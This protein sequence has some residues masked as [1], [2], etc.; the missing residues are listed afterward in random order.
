MTSDLG[1]KRVD[2]PRHILLGAAACWAAP[3]G[4]GC[5]TP[6]RRLNRP[7]AR[8]DSGATNYCL[9]AACHERGVIVLCASIQSVKVAA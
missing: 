7:V 5:G 8:D 3:W 9:S 2:L 4:W 6:R 1:P